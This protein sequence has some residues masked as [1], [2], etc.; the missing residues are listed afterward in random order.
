ML[1]YQNLWQEQQKNSIIF[2]LQC[3]TYVISCKS[4]I[5]FTGGVHLQIDTV[6]KVIRTKTCLE[7]IKDCYKKA[8]PS[9]YKE[10]AVRA[11]IGTIVITRFVA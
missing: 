8:G 4:I 3:A 1:L 2:I 7:I 6:S 10:A 5:L 9:G 11:L